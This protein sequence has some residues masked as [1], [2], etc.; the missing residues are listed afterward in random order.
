MEVRVYEVAPTEIML[1]H[2]RVTVWKE[3][4]GK[5]ATEKFLE[6]IYM[7]EH[8]PIYTRT[9]VVEVRGIKSWVATHFVR[10][11]IGYTPFVSTQRDDRI[12]YITTRDERKQGELVNMNID[13]N[14]MAFINVSKKRLCGQAHREARYVWHKVLEELKKVDSEL[15]KKCVPSCIYRGF[16][17]EHKS[18]GFD[19][20]TLA[21]RQRTEYLNGR[22]EIKCL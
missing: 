4:T 20:T 16:C 17:P 14:A 2:T 1:N 8:S 11:S 22:E 13:L 21:R 7:S 6:N 12:D 3:G 10:H 9:F 18:C 15:A 19:G 5:D